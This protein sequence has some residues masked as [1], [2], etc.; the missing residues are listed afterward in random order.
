M[1][2]SGEPGSRHRAPRTNGLS[3]RTMPAPTPA[4]PTRR[5][6]AR[7]TKVPRRSTRH[8]RPSGRGSGRPALP[9][10][11]SSWSD[12]SPRWSAAT[13][14]PGWN[15][16]SLTARSWPLC[17]RLPPAGSGASVQRRHA[18]PGRTRA[19]HPPVCA[20]PR[21][22]W[23][24]PRRPRRRAARSRRQRHPRVHGLGPYAA[25]RVGQLHSLC[26]EPESHRPLKLLLRIIGAEETISPALG[27]NPGLPPS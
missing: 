26:R 10:A 15:R 20:P 4:A 3:G 14:G 9:E 22:C 11:L 8:P 5:A 25:R 21:A 13:R 1:Y 18:R 19:G 16:A 23:P 12:N 27:I 2:D 17:I 6:R 7:A 24:V